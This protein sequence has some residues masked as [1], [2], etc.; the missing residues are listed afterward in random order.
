MTPVVSRTRHPEEAAE[1]CED[2]VSKDD[3]AR[4]E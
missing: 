2:A 4:R 1:R 3:E